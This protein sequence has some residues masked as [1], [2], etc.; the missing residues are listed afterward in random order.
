VLCEDVGPSMSFA[1]LKC[2]EADW[3]AFDTAMRI[4]FSVAGTGEATCGGYTVT[5]D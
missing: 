5:L 2:G 1:D 4:W 3:G